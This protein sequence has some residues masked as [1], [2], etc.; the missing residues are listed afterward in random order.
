M[1]PPRG[2][3]RATV[4]ELLARGDPGGGARGERG[5]GGARRSSA[6]GWSRRC[7]K[8]RQKKVRTLVDAL[9]A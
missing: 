4:P 7:R 8:W 9:A 1:P 6:I 5:R 3:G 2:W